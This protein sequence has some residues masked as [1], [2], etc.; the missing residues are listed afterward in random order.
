MNCVKGRGILLTLVA[1]NHHQGEGLELFIKLPIESRAYPPHIWWQRWDWIF[2]QGSTAT[3]VETIELLCSFVFSVK[4]VVAVLLC[5]Y[6]F[7]ILLFPFVGLQLTGFLIDHTRE[8]ICQG[9]GGTRRIYHMKGNELIKM[10]VHIRL[11][12]NQP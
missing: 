9:T 8:Q 1:A 5:S 11:P 6:F 2:P 12:S 7:C 3:P 4:I 10:L